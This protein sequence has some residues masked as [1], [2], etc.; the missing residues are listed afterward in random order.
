M[1][2]TVA[3][4]EHFS[5]GSASGSAGFWHNPRKLRTTN[6]G[7]MFQYYLADAD[8]LIQFSA[9]Q[10]LTRD[11]PYQADVLGRRPPPPQRRRCSPPPC[12][13]P[14][15][16]SP[17]RRPTAA[18]R[19]EEPPRS[20]RHRV[21]ALSHDLFFCYRQGA[22]TCFCRSAGWAKDYWRRLGHIL[23][24]DPLSTRFGAK[25]RAG[26]R[27]SP[28]GER[29]GGRRVPAAGASPPR[30]CAAPRSAPRATTAKTRPLRPPRRSPRRERHHSV[31]SV[32][33]VLAL[34]L[35]LPC[36]GSYFLPPPSRRSGRGD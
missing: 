21:A 33:L 12:R 8:L 7:P 26:F 31:L 13:R 22:A 20:R 10:R 19:A 24:E 28:Q 15:P 32:A 11:Q 5:G 27:R 25:R 1:S 14:P 18:G 30:R 2:Q 16:P 3:P 35:S 34:A 9:N 36:R 29:S 4:W 6:F 17:R 23:E